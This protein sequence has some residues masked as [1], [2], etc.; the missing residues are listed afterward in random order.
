VWCLEEALLLLR[1]R[2][3]SRCK[4]RKRAMTPA[5]V[6]ELPCTPRGTATHSLTHSLTHSFIHSLTH[7]LC[8]FLTRTR[9]LALMSTPSFTRYSTWPSDHGDSSRSKYTLGA[10]LPA[11]VTSENLKRIDNLEVGNAQWYVVQFVRKLN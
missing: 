1:C 5:P 6:E 7:S 11:D 2:S 4:K 9:Q 10:G 8:L 3:R